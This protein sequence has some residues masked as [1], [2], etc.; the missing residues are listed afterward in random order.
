[1][2]DAIDSAPKEPA[3]AR[4]Q[5]GRM[6]LNAILWPLLLIEPGDQLRHARIERHPWLVLEKLP[7]PADVGEAVPD[8]AGAVVVDDGAV[9]P[10]KA[11]GLVA[12]R[13]DLVA[14]VV[15]HPVV[16]LPLPRLTLVA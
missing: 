9:G 13:A 16:E 15:D 8:V 2:N 1:M 7:R 12:V 3:S 10:V 14:G 6:S 11:E 5:L 4:G